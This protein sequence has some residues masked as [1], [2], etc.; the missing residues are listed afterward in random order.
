MTVNGGNGRQAEDAVA[1]EL[2][3]AGWEVLNLNTVAGNWPLHDLVARRG[4]AT[5]VV[6]VAER[7]TTRGSTPLIRT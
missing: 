5:I 2:G 3:A 4:D 6:Q 1:A 7:G